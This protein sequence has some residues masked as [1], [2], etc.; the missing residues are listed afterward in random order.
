VT[1]RV[2]LDTNTI[3]S[4]LVF[5][6]GRLAW[7]RR[8]WQCGD[9]VPLVCNG[10]VSELLRV[11]SYP[12][13]RLGEPEIR[14]LLGDFL[15]YAETVLDLQETA[16]APRCCDEDDQIFIDLAFAAKADALV[17]GDADLLSLAGTSTLLICSPAE[18]QRRLQK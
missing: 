14:E 8:T 13:F 7:L 2:V 12:K 15:P 4:A 9:L 10:S 18:L 11:L 16:A 5:H 3:V 6:N 1:L 17:T